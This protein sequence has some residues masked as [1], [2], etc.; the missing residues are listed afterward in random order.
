VAGGV[1]IPAAD[2]AGLVVDAGDA[3]EI[4]RRRVSRVETNQP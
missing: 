1:R 2:L 4:D 3:A